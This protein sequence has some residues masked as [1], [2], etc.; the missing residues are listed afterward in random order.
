MLST[1]LSHNSAV[2]FI[3]AD[4]IGKV[5]RLLSSVAISVKE[6]RNMFFIG[7]LSVISLNLCV[8]RVLST[9]S[10]VE[11][12]KEHFFA[13]LIEETR[14]IASFQLTDKIEREINLKIEGFLE[15]IGETSTRSVRSH[16]ET[17]DLL[18]NEKSKLNRG[19]AG[20]FY[21]P[22]KQNTCSASMETEELHIHVAQLMS[23]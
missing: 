23:D 21:F 11:H 5:R 3:F 1:L 9:Q 8:N 15:V 4:S 19:P 20:D 6:G 13:N 18:L 16:R 22:F 7:L 17:N 10:Y 2:L 12:L 14:E